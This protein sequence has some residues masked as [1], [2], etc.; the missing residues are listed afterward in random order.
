MISMERANV[1]YLEGLPEPVA[2]VTVDVSFIGL[3]LVLPRVASLLQPGGQAVVLIKPQFEVGKGRVGKGGVVREPALHREVVGAG[4]GRC[5]SQWP[6][7]C[8]PD[9]LAD[10]GS[11]R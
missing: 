7:S 1:R 4:A 2:F 11:R 3:D 6:G 8:R 5:R 10:R 9:P